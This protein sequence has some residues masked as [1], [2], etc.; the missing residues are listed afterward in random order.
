MIAGAMVIP[1]KGNLLTRY[2]PL[3][4]GHPLVLAFATVAELRY[5]AYRSGWGDSRLAKLEQF[6]LSVAVVMPDSDLVDT[7]ARLRANCE[8]LGHALHA[9]VHDA[10]RW[11]AAT[12]MR[13]GLPLLS[14]D[15]IFDS[16][17][18]LTLR[19]PPR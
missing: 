19:R 12:A 13:Y 16:V 8:R 1:P 4:L 6:F 5:G 17:P 3:L 11:I 15:S 9:K 7:S 14:D 10:D 18:G 2:R